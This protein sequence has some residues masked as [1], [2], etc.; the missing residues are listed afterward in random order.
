MSAIN[1]DLKKIK[2]VVMDVDG[3]LSPSLIPTSPEGEPLRMVNVKDGYAIQLAV[4]RGIRIA[5]ITG[6]VSRGVDVRYRSL[7][8]NDVYM[9][10]GK[11]IGI[12]T[13]WMAD[14]S[15]QPEDVAY[16][17]DDVPD[18]EAMRYVGL[19]V[20]PADACRDI[21]DIADYISPYAGGHGVARDLIEQ[22]L[23][24]QGLW[25]KDEKAFG[26]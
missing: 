1:Y 17:G 14:N 25:L 13:G 20:A 11:K 21:L 12:L 4:K 6:A 15:L 8:V 9:G 2:A 23:R 24:A 19:S 10:A 18:Y 5:I 16:V 3:V 22:L 26:W 7:G